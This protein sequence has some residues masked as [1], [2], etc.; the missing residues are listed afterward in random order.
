MRSSA[1]VS[2]ASHSL[3]STERPWKLPLHK[4]LRK[5]SVGVGGVAAACRNALPRGAGSCSC[6]SGRSGLI[7]FIV[8]SSPAVCSLRLPRDPKPK[9]PGNGLEGFEHPVEVGPAKLFATLRS[10]TPRSRRP[11]PKRPAAEIRGSGPGQAGEKLV[12]RLALH[13]CKGLGCRVLGC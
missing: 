7:L 6:Q 11:K 2:K 12:H 3:V 8:Y 9:G 13:G 10:P 1:L 4:V 5:P